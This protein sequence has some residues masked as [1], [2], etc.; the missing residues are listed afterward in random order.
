MNE[1]MTELAYS[2]RLSRFSRETAYWQTSDGLHWRSG[3]REGRVEYGAVRKVQ[4]YQFRYF[5]SAATYWRCVLHCGRGRRVYLQAAHRVETGR[6]EDRS[7]SYFPFVGRLQSRI[8]EANPRAVFSQGRHWLTYVDAGLGLIFVGGLRLLRLVGIET[9]AATL[10][11]CMRKVGPRLRGHRVA[12]ANLIAAY[13]ERPA[14]EIELI[15]NGMWDNLGRVAAEYAFLE[16]L[17]DLD[18]TRPRSCRIEVDGKNRERCLEL[19]VAPG[20]TIMFGAHLANWEL[21]SWA[22]GARLGESVLVY[23]RPKVDPLAREL[24]RIRARSSSTLIPAD[25]DTFFKVKAAL[26]RGAALGMIVD[27]HYAQGIDVVFFGRP[28]KVNPLLARFARRY[29]CPIRGGR[30]VRLPAGRFRFEVTDPIAAPRDAAGKLDVAMTM[31][32]ITSIIE[33]WIRE[34]PDQWIWLH[35]RWR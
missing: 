3:R 5:G 20:P 2:F 14:A 19:R 13:P 23:R 35:R 17:W 30:I 7:P 16:R 25:A 11:W 32:M 26:E 12:R 6:I 8:A 9:A 31:Q 15:L 18:P 22:V 10:G 4:N 29:D 27:E 1:T 34:N 33:G 28:C 21:L 24:A